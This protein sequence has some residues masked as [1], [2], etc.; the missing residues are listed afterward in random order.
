IDQW[1][2]YAGN[3]LHIFQLQQGGLAIWGALAGGAVALFIYA[4]SQHLPL[5]R[6]VDAVVPGLLMAQIIGRI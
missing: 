5:G 1:E 3:P 6:L 4:K 2:Y